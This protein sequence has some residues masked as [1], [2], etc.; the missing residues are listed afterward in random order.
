MKRSHPLTTA[1]AALLLL[2]I[3]VGC[4]HSPKSDAPPAEIKLSSLFA[5]HMVLQRGMAVPVWGTAG[6]GQKVTVEVAGKKATARADKDG[7][8]TVK[9]PKLNAS[10]TPVMMTV[11]SGDASVV[12]NDVLVGD[13]WV[14]SGQSN[15]EWTFSLLAD[16][17]KNEAKLKELT[18]DGDIPNLRLF[19]FPKTTLLE[20]T[21][22]VR[23][24]WEPSSPEALVNFSA[25]AFY[26]GREIHEKEKVPVGLISNA[27]G[28]KP[29]ESFI[30]DEAMKANPAFKPLL[31][32]KAEAAAGFEQA[33]AEYPE[34]LAAWEEKNKQAP[35]KAG[36][37]PAEPKGAEDPSLASNIYNGMVHPI[38]PVAIKGAIWYQ[39]ESN[40]GRAE[41]YRTLFPAMIKDWRKQWG[42]GDF[43][44]IWVQLANFKQ[45]KAEPA[46]SDWA[47][48]R[49][50]QSMALKLPN[51]A[52][53]VII[54]IGEAND[55]HPRNKLDVGKRLALAAE[56][57]AY[58]K[59]D[60]VH[61]G[62]VFDS[63]TIEGNQ[64]RLKFQF[65]DGMHAKTGDK[66]TGFAVAGEDRKFVWAD[67]KIAGDTVIVSAPGVEKPVAVRYAWAD[68]PDC[69]LYNAA[70]LPASPFRTD[71]FPMITAGQVR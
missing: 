40:A 63:M 20:P 44:F 61:S 11:K 25:V 43:P 42:Q 55:I 24:K 4:S 53:A 23:G 1:A 50:A 60:V 46:D 19:T 26:F 8:F 47:E 22:N 31:D 59:N 49:E 68:N 57:I 64:A 48:L 17:G 18:K 10:N 32:K 27:W 45:R 56:R 6:P 30:S 3:S 41:Q 15:M 9:L 29:V 7:A 67:A 13:V 16:R 39:G 71:D 54:D 36:A 35:G 62:P 69:N 51:T 34:K 37:K 12:V 14:A 21:K 33:K 52:Q 66:V 2:F 5:D 65:A 38:I 28:G 58:G 70:G